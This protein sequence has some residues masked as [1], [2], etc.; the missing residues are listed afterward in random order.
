MASTYLLD[1][2]PQCLSSHSL[3]Q[4]PVQDVHRIQ[5]LTWG[6]SYKDLSLGHGMRQ[7]VSHHFG[8]RSATI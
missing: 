4:V 5:L 2:H 8:L 1:G 7:P 6:G 3:V